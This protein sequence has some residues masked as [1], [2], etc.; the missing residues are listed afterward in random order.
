MSPGSATISV[1]SSILIAS[2]PETWYWKWGASQLAVLASGLTS[3]DQRQPGSSTPAPAGPEPQAAPLPAADLEDLGAPVGELARLV[4]RAE[5]LVLRIVAFVHLAPPGH[6]P[7]R[8]EDTNLLVG[9]LAR[10][11]HHHGHPD[12]NTRHRR[13]A[14]SGSRLQRLQ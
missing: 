11:R 9:K 12:T 6:L 8:C 14:R 7:G 5:A 10:R 13:A 2:R 4:G 3:F 1:P